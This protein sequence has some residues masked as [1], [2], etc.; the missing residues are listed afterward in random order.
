VLLLVEFGYVVQAVAGN[1]M[2]ILVQMIV[3]R[4]F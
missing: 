4:K 2:A 1:P 3:T